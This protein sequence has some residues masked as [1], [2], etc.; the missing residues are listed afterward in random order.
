MN[1]DEVTFI[2]ILLIKFYIIQIFIQF[3]RVF[4]SRIKIN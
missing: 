2:I 3:Y 1:V 4:V